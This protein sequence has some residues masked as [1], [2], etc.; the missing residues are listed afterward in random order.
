MACGQGLGIEAEGLE[1]H[2]SST[3]INLCNPGRATK[4]LRA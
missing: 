2:P 4:L 1:F 3:T